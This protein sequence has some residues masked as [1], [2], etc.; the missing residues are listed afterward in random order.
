MGGD[1]DCVN[2]ADMRQEAWDCFSIME[3]L[4]AI[5]TVGWGGLG[6]RFSPTLLFTV[7]AAN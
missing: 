1:R 6:I 7:K 2:R 5:V 3:I 4:G